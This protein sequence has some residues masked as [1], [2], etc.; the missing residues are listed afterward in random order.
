MFTQKDTLDGSNM[1]HCSACDRKVRAEKWACFRRLPRIL[2]C[3]LLRYT[4]NVNTMQ[5]EKLNS[6]LA[7]PLR[8]SMAEYM[9]HVQMQT[10][11]NLRGHPIRM[12]DVPFCAQY[13]YFYARI[14]L[15][16]NF[17]L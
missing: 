16:K 17:F 12:F 6:Y 7:F 13:M 9:E 8:I 11:I 2:C 3:N 5:S 14:F 10:A 4:F 1:V 15:P